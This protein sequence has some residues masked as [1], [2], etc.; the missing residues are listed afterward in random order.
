ML[1]DELKTLKDAVYTLVGYETE[2]NQ[3]GCSPQELIA[4]FRNLCAAIQ[5]AWTEACFSSASEVALKR[6]FYFHLEGIR[7]I[8]DTL[9]DFAQTHKD[10]PFKSLNEELFS[11]INY[12]LQHFDKFLDYDTTASRFYCDVVLSSLSTQSIILKAAMDTAHVDKDLLNIVCHYF[13]DI[14][15][16]KT[17]AF[18]TYRNL[19]YME[20]IFR[21]LSV[22]LED[23]IPNDPTN[24]I[25]NKLLDLN[26]NHLNF[27]FYRQQKITELL[28]GKCESEKLEILR[29]EHL[30]FKFS[31]NSAFTYSIQWPSI[32]VMV[33]GWLSEQIAI[34]EKAISELNK[35]GKK[36][37][38]N[39]SVAQLACFIRLFFDENMLNTNN[40]STIFR[41]FA[42]NYQTKRQQ[43]ISAGSLSKEFYSTTQV[44]AAVVREMLL[45][46]VARI[47]HN[48]FPVLVAAS[49]TIYA[50]LKIR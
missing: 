13:E 16:D 46:M 3:S 14:T 19:F 18:Y 38:L 40:L 21:S 20:A 17:N 48:F 28:I 30:K 34:T 41:F 22:F 4:D 47:N 12:L 36:L 43:I 27:F 1:K 8:S 25:N 42:Q 7:H 26:F 2:S 10:G 23:K 9:F 15:T 11:L 29:Q 35:S 6:Y 33:T 45:K 44:T 31:A 32:G 39:L 5:N 37:Q 24:F 50:F 49:A